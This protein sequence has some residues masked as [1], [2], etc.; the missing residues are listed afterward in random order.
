MMNL[1]NDRQD[2]QTMSISQEAIAVAFKQLL[3]TYRQDKTQIATKE[4]EAQKKQQQELLSKTSDYTVDNIINGMAALQL[5][6]G[7]T[8]SELAGNLTTECHKLEELK[9]AIAV[10][11]I[12]LEQLNRV[13]LAADA[14]HILEREHQQKS[15]ALQTETA[16]IKETVTREIARTKQEWTE[17][18]AAFEAQIKE[19]A[20]RS[21]QERALETADYQYELERQRKIEQDEYEAEKLWQNR[22][23]S[24]LEAIKSKDW[25]NR[26]QQLVQNKSEFLK[27]SEKI[28][29]FAAQL[30][31]EYDRAR[32][33]AIKNAEHKYKI[34]TDLREKEWSAM[35]QGYDLKIASLTAIIE[36]QTEQASEIATQLQQTNVQAQNLAVQAFHNTALNN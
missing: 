12:H 33:K 20:E 11:Q 2:R 1:A 4:E 30:T 31:E 13:R 6:F 29:G 14:L 5:S 36:R 22:E 16:R 17:E 3:E 28:A 15:T 18:Q 34:A 10:E 9:G 25:Q 26:E 27:N 7:K 35:Q 24:E 8:I 21:A 32:V 23:L 19:T